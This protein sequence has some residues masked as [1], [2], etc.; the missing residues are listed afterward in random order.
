MRRVVAAAALVV[1]AAGSAGCM[2]PKGVVVDRQGLIQATGRTQAIWNRVRAIEEEACRRHMV[3]AKRCALA[4]ERDIE[5]RRM[6]REA[7]AA[8]M[9]PGYELDWGLI[10]RTL[11][12][13]G[14]VL[15]ALP[16]P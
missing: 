9:V 8:I 10:L 2:R 4:V 13:I 6:F 3:E 5:M 7:D 11:E 12:T 1:L 16:F 15:D 14:S